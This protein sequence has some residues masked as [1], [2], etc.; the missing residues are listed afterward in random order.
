MDV[1]SL[2][3]PKARKRLR[4]ESATFVSSAG[5]AEVGDVASV[6]ASRCGGV[7]EGWA[8]AG[9]PSVAAMS[10][11]LPDA[12]PGGVVLIVGRSPLSSAHDSSVAAGTHTRACDAMVPGLWAPGTLVCAVVSARS[13]NDAYLP[14]ELGPFVLHQRFAVPGFAHLKKPPSAEAEAARPAELAPGAPS[15]DDD[16]ALHAEATAVAGTLRGVRAVEAAA[17]A[18]MATASELKRLATSHGVER[19][20]P[21]AKRR[22]PPCPAAAATSG[23]EPAAAAET[24]SAV[25]ARLAIRNGW[26]VEGAA[27]IPAALLPRAG[28][29][30]AVYLHCAHGLHRSGV[31]AM[32]LLAA[33]QLRSSPEV[34]CLEAAAAAMDAFKAARGANPEEHKQRAMIRRIAAVG[35]VLAERAADPMAAA[36]LVA[37]LLQAASEPLSPV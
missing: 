37:R 20:A 35:A 14:A 25:L 32:S 27:A 12:L 13:S 19:A 21:P 33:A 26:T 6:R 11:P 17:S 2:T 8:E 5:P 22:P 7:P 9:P 16:D 29:A 30:P 4:A 28:D 23:A 36:S 15:L 31:V 18:A 34:S 3:K 10:V 24:S 1:S